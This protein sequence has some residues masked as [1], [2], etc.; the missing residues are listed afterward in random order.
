MYIIIFHA[1]SEL[2]SN[3]Q[4]LVTKIAVFIHTSS[5]LLSCPCSNNL[6]LVEEELVR[7]PE[8]P[9]A[10]NGCG[11]DELELPGVERWLRVELL[12]LYRAPHT[13]YITCCTACAVTW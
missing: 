11:V 6:E 5:F 9:G 13:C 1:K 4:Q 10:E 7:H 8:F 2:D 12:C 3:F